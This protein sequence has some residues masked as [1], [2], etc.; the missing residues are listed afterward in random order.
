M[1]A[2][3]Q[4]TGVGRQRMFGLGLSMTGPRIGDGTRVNPPLSLEAEWMQVELDRL[5]ADCLQLPVWM[6]N[7]AHC[8][9]LAE[10]VYGVGR[11]SPDLVYLYIADGF[12][13]GVT[14]AGS[15][16][17]G[18]HANAGEL[19]R[20][21]AITGMPRPSLLESLRR[22]LLPTGMCSG[23]ACPVAALRAQWPQIDALLDLVQP[24]VTLP[25]MPTR[26]VMACHQ[27]GQI[28][29]SPSWR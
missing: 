5:V 2:V 29:S 24:T 28:K 4:A 9:A 23:P 19:G 20:I 16:R 22:A 12:A 8:V 1:E 17:R 18:A 15:V 11:Q 7:D 14:A 27:M 6:D 26:P 10:A 13:A 21:S 25:I 3:L